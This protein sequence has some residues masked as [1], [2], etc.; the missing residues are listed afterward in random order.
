MTCPT[1]PARSTP[2]TARR[3]AGG[4]EPERPPRGPPPG[5]AGLRRATH[6]L[7]QEL[8]REHREDELA[9]ELHTTPGK[10]RRI[11]EIAKQPVSI[12]TPLDES[13]DSFLGDFIED[14]RMATPLEEAQRQLLKEEV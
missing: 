2:S 7:Q 3:P 4:T 6:Q 13:E 5:P 11:M 10:I 8:Q 14:D 9:A 12:D 1:G